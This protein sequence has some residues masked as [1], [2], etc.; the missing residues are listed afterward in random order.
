MSWA[1]GV[2]GGVPLLVDGV[3]VHPVPAPCAD[4]LRFDGDEVVCST[5]GDAKSIRIIAV[6]GWTGATRDLQLG[7]YNFITAGGGHWGGALVGSGQW[8]VDGVP[9]PLVDP[10]D[11]QLGN[12]P[13]IGFGRDGSVATKMNHATGLVVNGALWTS[14]LVSDVTVIDANTG[15]WLDRNGQIHVR[16]MAMPVSL[17]GWKN[18]L[19]MARVNGQWWPLYLAAEAN[20][21]LV[22]HPPDDLNG[23]A[24]TAPGAHCDRPDIGSDGQHQIVVV[25][26]TAESESV[27]QIGIVRLNIMHDPRY[28]LV[29][30][31][32]DPPN[33]EPPDPE[34]PIPPDPEPEPPEPQPEPPIPDIPPAIPGEDIMTPTAAA[35]QMGAFFARVDLTPNIAP[36]P[37]WF[38]VHFDRMDPSDAGCRFTLSQPQAGGRLKVTLDTVPGSL[39]SADAGEHG[40]GVCKQFYLKP[41]DDW[42]FNE[43]FSGWQLGSGGPDIVLVQYQGD[44]AGQLSACL[45]VVRL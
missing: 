4:W 2:G 32:P 20:G 24:F 36:W 39:L 19:R 40:G 15:C 22:T 18:H 37:G 23:Y 35:L 10:D 7:E 29:A 34:P 45:K 5:W 31:P 6:N 8:Q 42:G 16:G 30:V 27:G 26:G 3:V 25:W 21:Q 12:L 33:P 43:Q 13:V 28:P 44:G 14:E 38:L 41:T 11:P 9:T 17:P 1:A